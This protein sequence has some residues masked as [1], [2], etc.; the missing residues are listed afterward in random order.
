M[1]SIFLKRRTY[2]TFEECLVFMKLLTWSCRGRIGRGRSAVLTAARP[3]RSGLVASSGACEDGDDGAVS[4]GSATVPCR[5]CHTTRE[6]VT[7]TI[8]QNRL[9]YA[10]LEMWCNITSKN[11]NNEEASTTTDPATEKSEKTR[12]QAHQAAQECVSL[13]QNGYGP[14]D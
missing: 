13:G 3:V 6:M 12:S 10:P 14:M 1:L 8:R 7:G 5:C 9:L 4:P 2:S 11:A